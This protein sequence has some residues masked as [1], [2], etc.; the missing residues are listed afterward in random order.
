MEGY[1]EC[2]EEE[3]GIFEISKRYLVRLSSTTTPSISLLTDNPDDETAP[4]TTK[5]LF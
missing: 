5:V 3:G 1:L 4:P 2:L